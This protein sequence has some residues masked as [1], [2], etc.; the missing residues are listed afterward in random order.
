VLVM[1]STFPESFWMVAA[2]AAAAG[3]APV[4]A[5]HSGMAEV[6]QA[7]AEGLPPEAAGLVSFDL[8]NRAVES[9]AA[10]INGWL[11]LEPRTRERARS[12][13]REVAA[14]R[15]SW[16]GVA[17]GVVA[18]SAGRLDELPRPHVPAVTSPDGGANGGGPEQ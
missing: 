13:L 7:L 14:E 16:E 3:T 2:E 6:S 8:D 4:S 9:L 17:R 11:C 18:A 10:R 1:P 15:W 5:A 12:A